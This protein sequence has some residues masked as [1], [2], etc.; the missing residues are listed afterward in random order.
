M[1]P[2]GNLPGNL[3]AFCG[4]L[5][6]EYGFRIGAAERHDAARAL[7]VVP[8]GDERAVR[9]ALRP[10]LSRTPDDA[11]V[12]DRAFTEFFFPGPPGE[13]QAGLLR[14][15]RELESQASEGEQGREP[16][17]ARPGE[18]EGEGEEEEPEP[19]QGALG[20][21]A[22]GEPEAPAAHLARASYSP[23]DAEAVGPGPELAPVE[24]SWRDAAR[25]LV[26]RVHLGL[27][28]R[29]RPAARG[30]RFD[31]RRTL[32][33]S[34]QTGGEALEARWL[35]RPRRAPRFVLLIDGSRSMDVYAATA[36]QIAVA[37]ASATMRVE[38]FTFST[39]L[40][41]VTDDVRR[42]SAGATCRLEHLQTAWGGGTSIGACLREF[43]Q[44]FGGRSLGRETV[45]IVASD[46]L[47]VGDP[48][49][50]REAMRELNRHSAGLVWLNPLL[51]T[52][53][54]EPTAAGMSV[55][56]PF[57]DVFASIK[58]QAGLTRLSGLVR[59]RL[60]R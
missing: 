20:P 39:S 13:P 46:G 29:W 14:T 8:L 53:G 42:A 21:R 15:R 54:Y 44:Q 2:F 59:L 55:A 10:I 11:A 52:A 12:F 50:L 51:E 56:R 60:V 34:L 23:L 19:T 17:P 57:I 18:A 1:Y 43:L 45:V 27:S 22:V 35:R 30:R 9:N 37:I 24:P 40:Q 38:V 31:L 48:D 58:D 3:V 4:T 49:V 7:E 41:R 5:Q 26:H 25:V 36:L 6:R 47:D 28:R 32:R 16:V 33:A